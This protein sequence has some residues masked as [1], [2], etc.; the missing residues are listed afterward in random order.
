MNGI[1]QF[2]ETNL[3]DKELLEKIDALTDKMFKEQKI[4]LQHIP[5]EPNNDYDILVG[6]LLLRFKDMQR[7]ISALN[8]NLE[9]GR[10]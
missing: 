6:E 10:D 2:R 9:S 1:V 3:T 7:H 8:S 4:P 5:A